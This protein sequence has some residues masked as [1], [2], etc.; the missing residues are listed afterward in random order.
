M[1]W[2]R[3][4]TGIDKNIPLL[5]CD[6]LARIVPVRINAR[7]PFGTASVPPTHYSIKLQFLGL[8]VRDNKNR[9]SGVKQHRFDYFVIIELFV[10]A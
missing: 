8:D 7:P 5:A 2:S 4:P 1:A 3:R 10:I 9:P 6:L